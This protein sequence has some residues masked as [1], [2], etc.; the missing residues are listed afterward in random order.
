MTAN[1]DIY[2]DAS[3][4][5][6]SIKKYSEKNTKN[7]LFL[8]MGLDGKLHNIVKTPQG[9]NNDS[10]KRLINTWGEKTKFGQQVLTGNNDRD[11]FYY[12]I[13]QKKP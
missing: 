3:S 1:N 8:I 5:F 13:I 12:A 10:A 9:V 7:R 11:G 6:N 2:D 4:V